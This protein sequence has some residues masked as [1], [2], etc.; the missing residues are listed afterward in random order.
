MASA[1]LGLIGLGVLHDGMTV[2]EAK[3]ILGEP[4]KMSDTMVQWRHHWQL[5]PAPPAID[6]E[7]RD[8]K[9]TSFKQ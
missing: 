1:W 6:A 3:S 9:V 2:E 5:H 4:N 7:V 8:G